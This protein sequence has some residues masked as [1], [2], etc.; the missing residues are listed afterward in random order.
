MKHYMVKGNGEYKTYVEVL[1]KSS[2][3]YT[4]RMK[5]ERRWG[6]KEEIH[7]M[8]V[9]LFDTCLRTGYFIEVETGEIA[10]YA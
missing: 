4:I 1:E 6:F 5:H 3:G 10:R 7:R 2:S 8:S 9:N